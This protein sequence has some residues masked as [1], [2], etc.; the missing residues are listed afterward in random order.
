MSY[1]YK[2][3]QDGKVDPSEMRRAIKLIDAKRKEESVD[4][5][6]GLI[7]QYHNY[8]QMKKKGLDDGNIS[9]NKKQSNNA[10]SDLNVLRAQ[11]AA[12]AAARDRSKRVPCEDVMDALN[13]FYINE[14]K[15][16][17]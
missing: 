10:A 15:W 13:Y 11:A 3:T 1:A 9:K 5:I 8:F 14:W 4:N 17:C 6:I 16:W 12:F 2:I 7:M